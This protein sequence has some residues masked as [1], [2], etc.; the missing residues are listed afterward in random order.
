MYSKNTL[1]VIESRLQRLKTV[2][3]YP[4]TL[5]LLLQQTT[6]QFTSLASTIEKP[7]SFAPTLEL[8]K[9]LRSLIQIDLLESLESPHSLE[10]TIAGIIIIGR[11]I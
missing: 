8:L 9:S 2:H 4:R 10:I 1:H 3:K 5:I 7:E 6:N 11:I